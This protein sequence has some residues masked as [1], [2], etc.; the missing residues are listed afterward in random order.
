MEVE[1]RRSSRGC[2]S[3]L[4]PF[5]E[6]DW[7]VTAGPQLGRSYDHHACV[8]CPGVVRAPRRTESQSATIRL[9]LPRRGA[10]AELQMSSKPRRER[11]RRSRAPLRMPL[12]ATVTPAWP[13]PAD[14]LRWDATRSSSTVWISACCALSAGAR[15]ESAEA[16]VLTGMPKCLSRR[17]PSRRAT[18]ALVSLIAAAATLSSKCDT[19]PVPG[20]GRIEGDRARSQASTIC[21]GVAS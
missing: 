12:G 3:G 11:W 9:P 13:V 14:S 7:A 18:S 21:R 20:I 10:H 17:Y 8:R 6:K 16:W 5:V 1:P 4:E 19:D 15:L 2:S